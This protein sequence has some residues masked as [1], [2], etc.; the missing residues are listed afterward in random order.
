MSYPQKEV[1]PLGRDTGGD[2]PEVHLGYGDANS[3]Q[4]FALT[5]G[6]ELRVTGAERIFTDSLL[7]D[8]TNG[9]TLKLDFRGFYATTPAGTESP[10]LFGI[11]Q[12]DSGTHSVRR[13]N[14]I[15]SS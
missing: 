6:I 11:L 15:S 13:E 5:S 2:G 14:N 3:F 7:V 12:P 1:R 9:E 4:S 10:P 8:L